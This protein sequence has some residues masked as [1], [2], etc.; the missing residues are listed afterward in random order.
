MTTTRRFREAVALVCLFALT[1]L[2]APAAFA[3]QPDAKPADAITEVPTWVANIGE[4]LNAELTSPVET[5]RHAALR[6]IA[7][8]AY[9]YGDDLDLTATLPQ[10]LEIYENDPSERCRMISVAALHAIGDETAMQD[11]RRMAVM[12][13]EEGPSTRLHLVTLAALSDFYGSGTFTDDANAAK[14]ASSLL[15]YYLNPR[16]IVEPPVLWQIEQ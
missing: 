16:V 8:F 11:L 1:S 7:Y 6:H 9:F 4:Q 5:I 13:F 14:L 2:A 10:L 3:Q 12:D 15:D